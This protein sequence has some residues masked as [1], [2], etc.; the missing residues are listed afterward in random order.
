MFPIRGTRFRSVNTVDFDLCEGCEKL[1]RTDSSVSHAKDLF[2]VLHEPLPL[3]PKVAGR[4]KVF[5]RF[6]PP[7]SFAFLFFR[8]FSPS[9]FF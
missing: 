1:L 6:F 9:P 7:P 8:Q 4:G 5:F 3:A 2:V